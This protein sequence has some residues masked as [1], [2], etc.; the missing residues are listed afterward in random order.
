M[1]YRYLWVIFGG[2]VATIGIVVWGMIFSDQT[3]TVN[4]GGE[5]AQILEGDSVR[6]GL[7]RFTHQN[8]ELYISP[9]GTDLSHKV[10]HIP[11]DSDETG[12]LKYLKVYHGEEEVYQGVKYSVS[13]TGELTETSVVE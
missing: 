2:I 10:F 6:I 4:Y 3:L 9:I 1:K 12:K 7:K 8:G 5:R 13:E 11:V